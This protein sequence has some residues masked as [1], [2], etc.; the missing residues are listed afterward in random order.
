MM[1]KTGKMKQRGQEKS[2][3]QRQYLLRHYS[4]CSHTVI[5]TAVSDVSES[6]NKKLLDNRKLSMQYVLGRGEGCLINEVQR[7]NESKHNC[8][9]KIY[10]M[11][12]N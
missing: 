10:G 1:T 9:V 8:F 4:A 12:I 2:V 6:T 11:F 3:N 7:L 5:S